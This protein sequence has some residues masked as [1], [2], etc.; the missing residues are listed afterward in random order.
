MA[1]VASLQR[2]VDRLR[3]ARTGKPAVI[4]QWHGEV[5]PSQVAVL[6]EAQRQ[7]RPVQVVNYVGNVNP[8]LL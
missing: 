5:I 6:A 1:T 7:R 4:L 2:R 8:A 3:S